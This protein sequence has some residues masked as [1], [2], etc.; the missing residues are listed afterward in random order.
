MNADGSPKIPFGLILLICLAGAVLASAT[1]RYL[2]IL[3]ILSFGILTVVV[4]VLWRAFG[5]AVVMLVL[6]ILFCIATSTLL[7]AL[8]NWWASWAPRNL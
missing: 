2:E 7:L 5:N 4:F 1:G 8:I 6:A 3:E